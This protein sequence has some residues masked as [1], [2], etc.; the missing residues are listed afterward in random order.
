MKARYGTVKS[1]KCSKSREI[2]N[3]RLDLGCGRTILG[4]GLLSCTQ[5]RLNWGTPVDH[6]VDQG[7]VCGGCLKI[8][9]AY[10]TV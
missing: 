3:P 6:I 4:S 10:A 1:L 5:I 2:G 9:V 7:Q 8:T